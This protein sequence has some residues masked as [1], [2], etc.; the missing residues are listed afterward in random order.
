MIRSSTSHAV[1]TAI[2]GK[3]QKLLTPDHLEVL[4]ES[5]MHNVPPGSESHFKVV[6]VSGQFEGLGLV[7]RHRLVNRA[8]AEELAA[9]VHA[10]ALHLF[11]P[12]D[13]AARA[14]SAE[15]SPE[16]LGGGRA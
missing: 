16:C 12:G 6:A 13:W 5:H 8:V 3:L 4:N 1:Q 14:K 10:L 7:Q 11:T 9:S 2:E 15:D